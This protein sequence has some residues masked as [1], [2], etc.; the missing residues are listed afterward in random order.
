M[1]TRG[2]VFSRQFVPFLLVGAEQNEMRAG[3]RQ[4]D[5]QSSHLL[6]VV[7]GSDTTKKMKRSLTVMRIKGKERRK[8]EN[9]LFIVP[10][11]MM[12]ASK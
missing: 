3:S 4:K 5:F 11:F 9:Y 2:K 12:G 7:F 10:Q 1:R 8:R 6:S